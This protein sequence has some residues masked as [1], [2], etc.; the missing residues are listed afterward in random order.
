VT[1]STGRRT[2]QAEVV[3]AFVNEL[4]EADPRARIIVLGDLNDFEDSPP[5]AVLEA[6]GLEDLVNRLPAEIRYSYVYQGNSQVLDHVLVSPSLAAGAEVECA[7]VNSEFPASERAS[8]HDPVIV[9]LA[10]GD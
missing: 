5:L 8:D 7:P 6:A 3:A 2:A 1:G 4:V 9:R 10:I